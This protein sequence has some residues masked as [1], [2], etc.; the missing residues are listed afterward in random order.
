MQR[1]PDDLGRWS[2]K[3]FTQAAALLLVIVGIVCAFALN[4]ASGIAVWSVA[5]VFLIG[6]FFIERD[7][8]P[9]PSEQDE[10]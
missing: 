5:L 6:S 10:R 9:A 1:S 2:N 7:F 8:G 4:L 3:R